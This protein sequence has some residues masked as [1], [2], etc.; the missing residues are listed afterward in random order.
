VREVDVHCLQGEYRSAAINLANPLDR[1]LTV[2]VDLGGLPGGEH[3]PWLQVH[4]VEWIETAAGLAVADALPPAVRTDT[5]WSVSVPSGMTRQVWLTF[6]PTDL[7][8]GVLEGSIFLSAGNSS[9]GEPTIRLRL[10]VYPLSLPEQLSCSLGLWD[11]SCTLNYDLTD[12]NV[13]AAIVHMQQHFVDTPW[14][15]AGGVPWPQS[16]DA[17]GNLIGELNWDRFDGWIADWAGAKNYAVFLAVSTSVGGVTMDDPRFPRAVGEWMHVW[18]DHLRE[19]G[20]DPSQLMLLLVDEPYSQEPADIITAWARAINAAEPDIVVWED[21]TYAA[22]EGLTD[23]S[24]FEASDVLCPNLGIF[25]N[26]TD[27]HRAFYEKLRQQGKTLW[28]YQCSGPAKTHDPYTYHRLQHWYAF[29]YGAVGSGFWAY[30]DAAGVGTSWNEL[31]AGR[32]SFTPVYLD[33][34]SVVDG[35]HFEA[36]REGLEDYEVLRMLQDLAA[37]LAAEG[38]QA[39]ADRARALLTEAIDAVCGAGY[40]PSAIPWTVDKDRTAAD[41]M[42]VRILEELTRE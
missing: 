38:Q 23:I 16:F 13:D 34:E 7:K 17:E 29:Q 18:A 1:D 24:M 14:N 33:E 20:V 37:K 30:G 9:G 5:G 12:G 39:R 3:P 35:K 27:A 25:A 42:R 41:R 4:Q 32:A 10:H 40:D 2:T 15:D 6:H 26:G 21:P 8:P 31:R 28:F 11:F 22:P 19:I 36:V